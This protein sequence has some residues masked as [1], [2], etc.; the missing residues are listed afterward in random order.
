MQ[1]PP[2]PGGGRSG[3]STS[4]SSQQG[5]RYG[6]GGTVP[7]YGGTGVRSLP[8]PQSFEVGCAQPDVAAQSLVGPPKLRVEVDRGHR[9]SG[10]PDGPRHERRRHCARPHADPGRESVRRHRGSQD[11]ETDAVGGAHYGRVPGRGRTA[12][13]PRPAGVNV[14]SWI[15]GTAGGNRECMGAGRRERPDERMQSTTPGSS[16]AVHSGGA[17]RQ[18]HRDGPGLGAGG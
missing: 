2:D 8:R 12:G 16:R 18:R 9:R 3:K 7:S 13:S 14:E 5:Q 6:V 4:S 10:T 15:R 17:D 1:T 11:D